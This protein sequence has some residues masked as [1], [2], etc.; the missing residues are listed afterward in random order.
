V[1]EVR[2]DPISYFYFLVIVAIVSASVA[3][4][5]ED[6]KFAVYAPRPRYSYEALAR[7]LQGSGT[8]I[9][10]VEPATGNVTNVVMA[11]STGVRSLDDETISTFRRWRFKPGTVSKVRIP[12]S[13]TLSRGGG[14][15]VRVEKALPMDQVL[16]PFLGKESVINAPMPVY[17]SSQPWTPKEGRGV[18]EI[19]VDKGG[20]VTEVKI[21]KSSGDPT[22]DKVIGDTLH[23]WRLRNGP[24]IIEL[25]LMFVLTPGNFRVW[26]P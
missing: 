6:I 20:A 10:T 17:P 25:P 2:L 16:A 19:H 14:S 24:K 5:A 3:L 1:S 13:F 26:I 18:Y 9:L 21:L 8:A 15:I 7:R 23:K 11:T 12:I 22:F 4:A